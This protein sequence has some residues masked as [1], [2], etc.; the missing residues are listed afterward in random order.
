MVNKVWHGFQYL[1]GGILVVLFML[2]S[3]VCWV[4]F[5]SWGC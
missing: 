5:I 3:L 4:P 2:N 1:V